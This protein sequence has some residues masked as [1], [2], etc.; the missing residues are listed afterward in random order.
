MIISCFIALAP[1]TLAVCHDKMRGFT[2]ECNAGGTSHETLLG[3]SMVRKN[4]RTEVRPR[5]QTYT[6][7]LME[8]KKQISRGLLFSKETA[9]WQA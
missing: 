2:A 6:T 4:S 8:S 7:E 1:R 5:Q 9:Y 3:L